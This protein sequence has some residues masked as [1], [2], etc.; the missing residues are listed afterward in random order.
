VGEE[1]V[2][3]T[4]T[5]PDK[6]V[7]GNLEVS[8]L[9]CE[10]VLG[11]LTTKLTENLPSG[12][13]QEDDQGYWSVV[14]AD[15]FRRSAAEIAA[16]K[17]YGI[18]GVPHPYCHTDLHPGALGART[19]DQGGY[20]YPCSNWGWEMEVGGAE[21][22]GNASSTPTRSFRRYVTPNWENGQDWM[23]FTLNRKQLY[24]A[25]FPKGKKLVDGQLADV[26]RENNV[27]RYQAGERGVEEK[28]SQRV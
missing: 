19:P 10:A 21:D 5:V 23:L 26:G 24:G 22:A 13:L 15:E 9:S 20:K 6:S 3:C 4:A 28:S 1:W 11:E 7:L 25:K 2:R 17:T 27:N 14:G 12:A 8:W 18:P 16:E